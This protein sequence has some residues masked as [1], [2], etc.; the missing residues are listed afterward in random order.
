[1]TP[2]VPLLLRQLARW[3]H[4]VHRQHQHLG[5]MTDRQTFEDVQTGRQ[6]DRQTGRQTDNDKG[7]MLFDGGNVP[8]TRCFALSQAT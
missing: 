2:L 7:L 1:M 3:L 4:F 8:A 5:R 6:R